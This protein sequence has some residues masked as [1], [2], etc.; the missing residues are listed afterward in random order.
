MKGSQGTGQ[1]VE[2][3]VKSWAPAAPQL[4]PAQFGDYE[5]IARLGLVH[6]FEVRPTDLWPNI[7]LENPVWPRFAKDWSIGWVLETADGEIVGSIENF[8][9][10]Y[11]F[12]GEDLVCANGRAWVVSAAYRGFALWLMEEY[13][14]QTRVD[15]FMNTTVNAMAIGP[16]SQLCARIPLG[17]WATVSFWVIRYRSFAQRA[18]QKRHVPLAGLLA[19]PA[20]AVLWLKEALSGKQLAKLPP[21][22]VIETADRFDSRFDVFWN[23]LVR[24]N[25]E[26]LLAQRDSRTLSWHFAVPMHNGRMWL[27][28]ASREGQLRG[29]CVLTVQDHWQHV[30]RIR[31]ID[32]QS[33][34]RDVDLL[35]GLLAA[36]LR[37][38]AE[39]DVYVLENLGVGVPKMRAFDQCAPY[40]GKQN[41]QFFYRAADPTLDAELRQPRF[42]EPSAFDGDASL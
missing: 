14:N 26:T 27:F 29:Y 10:L 28:T 41:W 38:C 9:S 19:Y 35:P 7:W 18:F 30:R 1:L 33:I 17:D 42:W 8:P 39:E 37:R 5:K 13:L 3:P 22:I 4:R 15:L 23:E 36:V 32:Y 6:T 34:D 31:L 40:R 16:L 25:P 20:G 2:T 11:S 12:R 21:S 24:Q